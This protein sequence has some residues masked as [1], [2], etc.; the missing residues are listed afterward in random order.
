MTY[1]VLWSQRDAL[2]RG[3]SNLQRR[4]ELQKEVETLKQKLIHQ[5]SVSCVVLSTSVCLCVWWFHVFT[6]LCVLITCIHM[7]VCLYGTCVYVTCLYVLCVCLC[8][9]VCSVSICTVCVLCR[10]G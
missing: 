4:L 6:C 9:C 8:V 1:M 7:C 2:P 3:D 5:V 10:S